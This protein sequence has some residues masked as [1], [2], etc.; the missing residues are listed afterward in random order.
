VSAGAG[1]VTL[2]ALVA[3]GQADKSV[4]IAVGNGRRVSGRVATGTGV[5]TF[6][7]R[8]TGAMGI[9]GGKLVKA[10]GAEKLARTQEHFNMEHRWPARAGTAE[11]YAKQPEYFR[12]KKFAQEHPP[13]LSLYPDYDYSKGHRWA[14]T[15]DLGA[16][17]GCGACTVACQAENN[18]P[19]VGK[20]A[21]IRS[22][23]MHWIRVDRYFRGSP[24]EP[25]SVTQPMPCQ[26]CENAP[27]EQV[28]PVGATNHSPEGLNDMAYNRCI[29]TKYCLNNCP[30]K[31]RRFNY[32]NYTKDTPKLKQAQYNP[33]V[34]VRSRGVMEKCTYCVQ[35][36]NAAKIDGHKHGTETIADGTIQ[37][38]CQQG[39]PT[40]AITFGDL[41]DPASAVSKLKAEKRS[42]VLLEEINVRARTTYL[43]RL[44]NPN[45][46]IA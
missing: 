9:S 37:T 12:E 5:D 2:P 18:I 46:E 42:Y 17:I 36:I 7:L 35:R 22:R 23:E 39:C 10:G 19:V 13:L 38:A 34:T 43:A 4:T 41:N 21:V 24:D 15:I 14:M 25:E 1:N 16:C 8:T 27:C 26:Q 44:T 32:F 11:E 33:D 3:V 6:P 28:C 29:G 45:P 30:F 20:D 31:V 40:R